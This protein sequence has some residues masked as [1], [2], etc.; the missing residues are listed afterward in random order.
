MNKSA[1]YR[2]IRVYLV[3]YCQKT[4]NIMYDYRRLLN[5]IEM[6]STEKDMATRRYLKKAAGEI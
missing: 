4:Q 1:F 6:S 2:Y 5:G 3:I